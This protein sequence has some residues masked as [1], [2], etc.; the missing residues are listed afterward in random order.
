MS[1]KEL[2]AYKK[3]QREAQW[4]FA[5]EK[6]EAAAK[7]GKKKG[8]SEEAQ[9]EGKTKARGRGGSKKK[10]EK[11]FMGPSPLSLLNEY[12]QKKKLPKPY[13]KP[14]KA[15]PPRNSGGAGPSSG[16][17]PPSSSDAQGGGGASGPWFRWRLTLTDKGGKKRTF[18]TPGSYQNKADAKNHTA[19]MG[20]HAL[21]GSTNVQRSL[22]PK[23]GQFW[24][25]LKDEE[26]R[27]E[28]QAEVKAERVERNKKREASQRKY[29]DSLPRV[30][31]SVSDQLRV[32]EMLQASRT[33]SWWDPEFVAAAEEEALAHDGPLPELDEK[34]EKKLNALG[35]GLDLIDEARET[36]ESNEYATLLDWLIMNVPENLLPAQFAPTRGVN[37][38]NS[39]ARASMAAGATERDALLASSSSSISSQNKRNNSKKKKNTT[40]TT[41]KR[42]EPKITPTGDV[43]ELSSQVQAY[44]LSSMGSFFERDPLIRAIERALEEVARGE[45]GGHLDLDSLPKLIDVSVKLYVQRHVWG[46][47]TKQAIQ[48]ALDAVANRTVSDSDSEDDGEEGGVVADEAMVLE[49]IYADRFSSVAKDRWEIELEVGGTLSI[50]LHQGTQYPHELPSI[51]L[52]GVELEPAACT[53]M[54]RR[55]SAEAAGLLGTPLFY[56][57]ITWLEEEWDEIV[58][59]ASMAVHS[60]ELGLEDNGTGGGGGGGGDDDFEAGSGNAGASSSSSSNRAG[61]SS[62]RGGA[63]S[64]GQ[65][66]DDD[67]DDED[68]NGRPV[69]VDPAELGFTMMEDGEVDDPSVRRKRHGKGKG[70]GR[71]GGRG[72]IWRP[73]DSVSKKEAGRVSASMKAELAKKGKSSKK[74][75]KM[76]KFRKQ[77]PAYKAQDEVVSAVRSSSVVVISGATGC[78]KTTQVPQLVLDDAIRSGKGA[79]T[80]I[81]CTQPR[82][83]A[84]IGVADRVAKERDGKL[85]QEIGYHIRLETKFSQD[86]RLLFCTTG[87]LLRYLQGDPELSSVSHVMV[88]EVHERSVQSDFLLIILRKLLET[89]P[90][91]KIV[92]MSATLNAELFSSYFGGVPTLSIPGRTFPVD[93]QYLDAVVDATG[94][95]I[96]KKDRRKKKSSAQALGKGMSASG[97]IAAAGGAAAAADGVGSLADYNDDEI[98]YELLEMLVVHIDRTLPEGAILVFMSGMAEIKTLVRGL[99]ERFR[100]SGGG[101]RQEIHALHSSLSSADQSAIFRHPPAGTRKIVVSTN[102]AETSLTIDDVVYVVDTGKVKETMYDSAA[103]MQQLVETWVS[104]AGANQRAGRAGR[105]QAGT[106]FR[107]YT[108]SRF[109]KMLPQQIPEIQRTPLENL[110][111]QIQSLS[112]M[113]PIREV[114]GDAIEPPEESAVSDAIKYLQDISAVTHEDENVITPLGRHLAVFPLDVAVGKVLLFGALFSC[115]D[116][117]LT[118]AAS[119]GEK[120]LFVS[121]FEERDAADAAHAKFLRAKSDLL[122]IAYAYKEWE[123]VVRSGGTRAGY[124]FCSENYLSANGMFRVKQMKRKLKKMLEDMGFA[125]GTDLN[126]FSSNDRVVAAVL[127]AG[128]YPRVVKVKHPDKQYTETVSGVLAKEVY[129]AKAIR[130]F[131]RSEGRVFVHPASLLFHNDRWQHPFV[132][133]FTKMKTSKI[134]LRDANMISPYALLLFGGKLSVLHAKGQITVDDWLVMKSPAKV[135]IVFRSLR[136]ELNRLLELKIR[137]PWVPID[138]SPMIDVVVGL[139]TNEPSSTS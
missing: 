46:K 116:P 108:R 17:A 21:L 3:K 106:C 101:G 133:Y 8:G 79:K 39:A 123:K 61:P 57:L 49:S 69:Y 72:G 95:V 132:A 74:Y 80:R 1:K 112:F 15:H 59:S 37:F 41:K 131:S 54:A 16:S 52:L 2:R 109:N 129:E 124:K 27:N 97:A 90:D 118:I 30:I 53:Q 115:L 103:M 25:F 93:I 40:A 26:T 130:M 117:I 50:W 51:L 18:C 28:R 125:A 14:A 67:D 60:S 138:Q 64:R 135:S 10:K 120:S 87:I 107:M 105:V 99:Q 23:Y 139:F 36:A 102:I 44:L 92:L 5:A 111:L 13:F 82:R 73:L 114:L 48:Q 56:D 68:G 110:C 7:K 9:A 58:T 12:C 126:R 19:V 24:S 128:L 32:E 137:E 65:N 66:N 42:V 119:L 70:R 71:G 62:R 96:K 63:S 29:E 45:E 86:T 91:L 78:G 35:F 89:R 94:Y 47:S 33:N 104:Q 84:A 34:T 77:L 136:A 113:G 85:G 76:V 43:G 134:Y 127:G 31:L 11:K 100:R 6:E 75:Q 20:L 22:E 4:D 55:I 38:I 81:I 88:D 121:P 122:S 83:L 98:N